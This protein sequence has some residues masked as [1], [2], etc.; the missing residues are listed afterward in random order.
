[1]TGPAFT[2]ERPGAS[3]MQWRRGDAWRALEELRTDRWSHALVVAAHPDDESLGTGGLLTRLAAAG[4]RVG[5]IVMT[6]GEASHPRST[7]VS[8]GELAER[9]TAESAAAWRALRLDAGRLDVR[10]LP[11]GGLAA[12][13]E[14]MAAVIVERVGAWTRS[15]PVDDRD[16]AG[17]RCVIIAPFA[18][19]GHPDH[20]AVAAAAT[21]AARRA[22]ADLLGF[23]LWWWQW[24]EPAAGFPRGFGTVTLSCDELARKSQA[25][26]CHGTQVEPLSPSAGDEVMIGRHVLAHALA[27]EEVFRLTPA[28]AHAERGTSDAALDDLHRLHE[29]PWQVDTSWYEQRKRSLLMAM[30]PQARF[31]HAVEVGCSTGALSVDLAR[32]CDALTIIDASPQALAAAERRFLSSGLATPV[33][34]LLGSAPSVWPEEPVDLVVISEVGYFLSPQQLRDLV[35]R[36][37]DEDGRGRG[38]T[39]VLAHWRHAIEGW[40]MDAE[41]VHAAFLEAPRPPR[42]AEYR[43]DDVEILVLSEADWWT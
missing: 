15:T 12:H 30:L 14:D 37:V 36:I 5:G 33:H 20:E 29:E 7:T 3:P 38:L 9:R 23:P 40:P 10:D 31:E 42:I 6:R 16:P 4:S 35:R 28:G 32:R 22:D 21:R 24:A 39:V 18:A 41:A 8:P 19:D 26:Y 27:D 1:M 11:D 2:H 17:G 25:V 43:D 13:V 34:A